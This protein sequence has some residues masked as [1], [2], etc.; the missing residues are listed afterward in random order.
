[1]A[2]ISL[3]ALA[4]GEKTPLFDPPATT[5]TVPR[6]TTQ[7]PTVVAYEYVRAAALVGLAAAL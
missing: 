7:P 3:E 5:S 1:M 4:Y 2:T 6:T